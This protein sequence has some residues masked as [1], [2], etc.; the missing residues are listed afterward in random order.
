MGHFIKRTC[1]ELL[2]VCVRKTQHHTQIHVTPFTHKPN[3]QAHVPAAW[4]AQTVMHFKTALPPSLLVSSFALCPPPP[5]KERPNF[6]LISF[7]KRCREKR[8]KNRTK[9]EER[10]KK[11]AG[12]SDW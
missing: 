1:D 2:S 10:G 9:N 6:S 8:R 12:G 5:I 7:I 4:Y 3:T 11:E